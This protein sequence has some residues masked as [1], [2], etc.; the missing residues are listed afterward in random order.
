MKNWTKVGLGLLAGIALTLSVAYTPDYFEISKQLDIFTNVFKEVNLYYVDETEPGELMDE[1]IVSMLASLDPYTNYIPE[2]MVEDY[3]IQTTGNYGGIGATI[4]GRNGKI[5]V[6]APYKGFAADKANLKAGDIILKVDGKRVDGKSTDDVTKIL[7]GA[8]GTEV[9]ITI[10]REGKEIKKKLEREEVRVKSVP[11]FGMLN[12]GIGYITLSSFTE[13]ASGE[14]KQALKTLK[15]ENDLKGL[16]LDLRGN[17]GGLLSEAINVTNIFI[18]KGLEVVKT[19]GKLSDWEKTYKTLNEPNDTEIPLAVLINRGSASASEIVAGTLQDYDRAVIIGQRSFGK[20]L[21]QQTRKLSFGSQLKVTIAKYYTPSGRCIQAINYAE[22]AEDGS[23][24]KIPDSLRTEFATNNGRQV[25]DGGGVDPDL[26]LKEEEINELLYSLYKKMLIFDWATDYQ[27]AHDGIA[28][29]SAFELT[30]EE[31]Q[32]F[33]TWLKDR[34]FNYKT[35]TEK[36]I[37]R[38]EEIAEEEAY[39]A[40]IQEELKAIK[41]KYEVGEKDSY[42]AFK[43]DIKWLLEEEIASRYY[44]QEGRIAN[45]LSHDSDISAARKTLLDQA[46]YREILTASK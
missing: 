7:K 15:E 45:A 26:V 42:K 14:I 19:K 27:R 33:I 17:P 35:E 9:T 28:D 6:T 1:A 21:V 38:L 10:E 25:F 40:G 2:E 3:K 18:D 37:E 12:D 34:D 4:R 16:V 29:A 30:E 11:Y 43:E 5:Y 46:K 20:G 13:K 23:V 39:Y 31:Y 24:S 22:R 41:A 36:A 44:Y 32:S 8:P